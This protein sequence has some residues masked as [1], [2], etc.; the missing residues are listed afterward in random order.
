MKPCIR[1]TVFSTLLVLAV[2]WMGGC[3]ASRGTQSKN[4][5]AADARLLQHVSTI[6]L[7]LAYEQFEAGDLDQAEVTLVDALGRDPT[8]PRMH[9]LAGRIALERGQLERS[10]DRLATAIELDPKAPDGYYYQGIVLQRWKRYDQAY[11]AYRGAYE[12]QPDNITF[13]LAMSEM[14]VALDR[15]DE[16]IAL[17]E[18]K[19]DYFSE[20]AGIRMAVAELHRMLG[21][22]E[23]AI[24]YFRQASLLR[25]DDVRIREDLAMERIAA[26]RFD[27]AIADL[28][29]VLDQAPE[30]RKPQ[31]MR[32]L[33]GSYLAARRFDKAREL[34]IKLTRINRDDADAWIRLAEISLATREYAAALTAANRAIS[35]AGTRP[36]GY[37]VAGLVWKER[38]DTDKALVNFDRAA[39]LA[40][41]EAD[42][43]IL[44]GITLEAAGRFDAAQQAY[45]EARRRNPNDPRVDKLMAG[46]ERKRQP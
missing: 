39:Q 36:E 1:H 26:G 43:V 14:L 3:H 4:R 31:L 13:L 9:L 41:D 37:L 21:R 25:P 22:H 16:A 20:N 23:K 11:D 5:N 10:K 42:A 18:G 46:V 27:E 8:N 34:Y 29:F 12:R 32:S 33:A 19:L 40:P 24:D 38:G 2:V 30:E 44:R 7:Q 35:L 45:A 15:A 6:K 17:L 28:E